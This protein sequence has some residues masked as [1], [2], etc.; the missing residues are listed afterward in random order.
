MVSSRLYDG[1]GASPSVSV[2][3][4]RR[5][6]VTFQHSPLASPKKVSGA[7]DWLVKKIASHLCD[8][9]SLRLLLRLLFSS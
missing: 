8:G 7:D 1:M 4:Q 5:H 9:F 6:D 3:A 2:M